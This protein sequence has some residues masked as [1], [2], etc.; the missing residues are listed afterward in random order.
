MI[1]GHEIVGE[2]AAIGDGVTNW[3][4]GDRAG[5]AWHGGHDSEKA[6]FIFNHCTSG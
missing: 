3:K 2:V 5:G 4:Q 1:P 6:L